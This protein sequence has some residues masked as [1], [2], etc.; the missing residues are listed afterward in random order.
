MVTLDKYEVLVL[1][2]IKSIR[3]EKR[4]RPGKVEIHDFLI[5][6]DNFLDE[7]FIED[8][9]QNMITKGLITYDKIKNSF[10]ITK[11][12]DGLKTHVDLYVNEHNSRKDSVIDNDTQFVE[13]M[14]DI[15][16]KKVKEVMTPFISKLNGIIKD[17][18]AIIQEKSLLENENE[19][20]EL[21]LNTADREL[22]NARKEVVFSKF[23]LTS[24]NEI[25]QSIM[26]K[27]VPHKY[28]EKTDRQKKLTK[29]HQSTKEWKLRRTKTKI[30]IKK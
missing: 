6:Y 20:L 8:L 14:H 2:G 27:M 16:N 24:K 21:K 22:E 18:D 5:K 23:E 12:I 19:L 3:V 28:G 1:K 17:Y 4:K 13:T 26:K 9:I 11:D 25:I 29:I 10:H 7:E 30:K 15:V